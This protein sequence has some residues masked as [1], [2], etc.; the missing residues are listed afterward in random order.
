MLGVGE[1]FPAFHLNAA[2]SLEKGKEFAEIHQDTYADKWSKT[3]VLDA[4]CAEA[5]AIRP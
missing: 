5:R 4:D 1:K 3:R 2:V